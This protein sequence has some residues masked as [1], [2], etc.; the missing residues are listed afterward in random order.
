MK[1]ALLII[2]AKAY[3]DHEYGD[4]KMVLEANGCLTHTASTA[5]QVIGKF[6]GKTK[7]D[8]LL[9]QVRVQNYDAVIFIGGPGAYSLFDNEACHKIACD[10]LKSKKLTCAIC[11]APSILANAGL[12]EGK[13][14]TCFPDQRENLENHGAKYTGNP[15][16]K[17]GLIITA[18]G[19]DS[20]IAFG[21]L[22]ANSL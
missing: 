21:E 1:K 6:E 4:T 7:V 8:L 16:E 20:A 12:L 13:S 14:A 22:I 17:D 3:Q 9:K 5:H 18:D 2:A 10:A 11:A 15:T 19:P